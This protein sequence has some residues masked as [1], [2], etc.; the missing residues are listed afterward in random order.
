[1]WIRSIQGYSK[2]RLAVLLRVY[3]YW[4][5]FSQKLR[6]GGRTGYTLVKIWGFEKKFFQIYVRPDNK[7]KNIYK[8]IVK[9]FTDKYRPNIR[10]KIE[11]R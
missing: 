4:M 10:T 5:N 1:M 7:Y 3:T 2:Q 11:S 9:H 6:H 8:N